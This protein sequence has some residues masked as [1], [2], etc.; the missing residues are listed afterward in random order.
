EYSEPK[1]STS[2]GIV[3]SQIQKKIE[4]FDR[5]EFDLIYRVSNFRNFDLE[6]W[7]NKIVDESVY[8]GTYIVFS[9][10]N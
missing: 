2:D 4:K 7:G 1:K 3:Y 8:R 10:Q 6:D 5:K 9:Y